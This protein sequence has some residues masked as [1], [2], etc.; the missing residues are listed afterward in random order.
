MRPINATQTLLTAVAFTLTFT[1]ASCTQQSSIPPQAPSPEQSEPNQT[2]ELPESN[3]RSKSQW[4]FRYSPNTYSYTINTTPSIAQFPD[5]S[6]FRILPTASDTV[7]IAVTDTGMYVVSPPLPES[8]K[9]DEINA[10]IIR[11]RDLIPQIPTNLKAGMTWT[12]STTTEGCRGS[13][14]TLST[15]VRLYQVV[16]DT[17]FNDEPALL[18]RKTE[19]ISAKGEGNEGQHRVQMTATGS[20]TANLYFNI[21]AGSFLGMTGTQTTDLTITASGRTSKFLQR[22]VQIVQPGS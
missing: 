13:I 17:L 8:L 7:A 12:D 5:T 14:P 16:G 18:I 3:N 20:G 4:A 6:N 9:C 22:I 1:L 21:L 11:A 2:T 19:T 10:L 15:V